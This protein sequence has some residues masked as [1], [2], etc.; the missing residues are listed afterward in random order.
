MLYLQVINKYN[1]CV[2]MIIIILKLIFFPDVTQLASPVTTFLTVA[3]RSKI[4]SYYV[5]I[6][7]VAF[8]T[9]F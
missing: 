7:R 4:T 8:V 2:I 3:K 1:Y 6:Q 5:N 9:Q